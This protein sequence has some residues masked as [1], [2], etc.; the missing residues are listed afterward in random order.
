MKFLAIS[1]MKDAALAL[2]PAMGIQLIESATAAI[3]Q[4]KK[5][6][7][8]LE[9][10]YVPGWSRTVIVQES[11]TAEEALKIMVSSPIY[12]FMD[13]EIYPLA[14]GIESMKMLVDTFKAAQ[15][16]MPGVPK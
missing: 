5:E 11:K 10:Y 7:K 8:V 14:D 1:K 12:S 9:V 6:G 2:P 16:M 15:K 4:L 3:N 13:T